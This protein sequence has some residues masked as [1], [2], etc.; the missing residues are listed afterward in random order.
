M[1][2][3]EYGGG[4]TKEPV[5]G[6][7]VFEFERIMHLSLTGMSGSGKSFW[8]KRLAE[9]GF[10]CFSCDN[11]IADKLAPRLSGKGD[12]IARLGEWMG[13]PFQPGYEEREAEYLALEKETLEEAIRMLDSGQTSTGASI[14]IDTTGSVI[15]T[16]DEILTKLRR[17]TTIVHLATPPEVQ[18]QMLESY[19][20]FPRPVLWRGMFVKLPG[21]TDEAA[22]ARCY[23]ELLASRERQYEDFSDVT[24]P[25][26]KHRNPAFGVEQFLFNIQSFAGEKVS[27]RPK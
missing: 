23:P 26:T 12:A 7:S 10:I 3:T 22:L 14:A 2:I 4:F 16:G 6:T 15:Y 21:E 1:K 20:A 5:Q 27:S 8:S 18:K 11:L 24:I 25:Y 9:C 19:L 17:L 13:F